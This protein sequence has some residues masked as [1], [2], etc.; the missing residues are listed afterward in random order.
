MTERTSPPTTD[1]DPARSPDLVLAHLHLRLGSLALARAELETLAGRDGLDDS[2]LVDLAEARWRTGDADGAGEAA[3]AVLGEGVDG[4][5]VALVIAAEAAI[6]RGR[7]TEARRYATRAMELA[8]GGIDE[9]FAGM[10]RG[11][12]WPADATTLAQ[13]APTLF[14]EPRRSETA[15]SRAASTGATGRGPRRAGTEGPPG[16]TDETVLPKVSADHAQADA[17]A[18]DDAAID[19]ATRA[20][21][22]ATIALW[23]SLEPPPAGPAADLAP[24]A[25]E[26]ADLPAGDDALAAGCESL[27]RGDLAAAAVDLALALRLTPSLAPAILD[28]IDGRTDHELAF[29]R[30]D[31]YRLVGRERE[32][33]RAYADAMRPA[34]RP[35]STTDQ[36]SEGDPA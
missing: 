36:S 26:D 6:L 23:A 18:M 29:V 25:A 4:P 30:G 15:R 20:A 2:G 19:A 5:V 1:P 21:E 9:V 11:P 27:A 13:P 7:P 31:A 28:A 35:E 17:V 16:H 8:G 24:A 32:A 34:T 14:D 12:V 22:P 3:A 10:P 33:R